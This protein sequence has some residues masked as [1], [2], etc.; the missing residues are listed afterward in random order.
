MIS[1]LQSLRFIFAIM[2]FI[3]HY[4]VNGEGLFDAGGTCGVSFL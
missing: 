2:I 4:T 1:S 3:H